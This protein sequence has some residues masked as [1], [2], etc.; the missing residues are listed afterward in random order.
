MRDKKVQTAFR[1]DPILIGRLKEAARRADV[2]LNEYVTIILTK[3]TEDVESE[4]EME[5]N[6]RKTEEFLSKITMA[7]V[8]D[9]TKEQ[10]L[11]S[12]RKGRKPRKTVEL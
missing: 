1:F 3:A 6:K 10:I 12:I 9:E 7:W 2:S 4:M 8:G 5:D 11:E